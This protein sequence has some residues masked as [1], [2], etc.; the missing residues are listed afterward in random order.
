MKWPVVR[1]SSASR[2]N[3]AEMSAPPLFADFSRPPAT[4]V[5]AIQRL[6]LW[7]GQQPHADDAIGCLAASEGDQSPLSTI[8]SPVRL[9]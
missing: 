2:G 9:S 3:G 5:E 8:E 6:H 4:H 1:Y 7:P